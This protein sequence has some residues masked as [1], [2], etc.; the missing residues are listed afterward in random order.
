MYNTMKKFMKEA[1]LLVSKEH[2]YRGPM[3]YASGEYK[4]HCIVSGEFE[5][6]HGYEEI[7]YN[8]RRV[9]ECIFHGGCV[10]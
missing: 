10:R 8:N 2:P 1:L 5:W 6:F 3:V 4:Y 7:Y 9:Y